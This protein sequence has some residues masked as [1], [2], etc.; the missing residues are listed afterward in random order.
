[1]HRIIDLDEDYC[2]ASLRHNIVLIP[3]HSLKI[4]PIAFPISV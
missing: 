2:A 1:L 4:I 3:S